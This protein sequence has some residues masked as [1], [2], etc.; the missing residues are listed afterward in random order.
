[1]PHILVPPLELL[2]SDHPAARWGGKPR[3]GRHNVAQRGT[4]VLAPFY[5]FGVITR[6]VRAFCATRDLLFLVSSAPHR[7]LLRRLRPFPGD[8]I[9][10]EIA[11][12]SLS[13]MPINSAP[14]PNPGMQ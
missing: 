3:Q 8:T 13:T 9:S 6:S 10:S 1:M 12:Y 14:T 11:L 2:Q 5:I 7:F 4:A